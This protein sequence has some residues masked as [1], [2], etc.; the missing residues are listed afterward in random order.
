MAPID[1]LC[2]GSNTFPTLSWTDV[3]GE[4]AEIAIALSDQTDPENPTLIWLMVGIDPALGELPGG[5]LPA[6]AAETLNDYAQLGYGNPCLEQLGKR[7]PRPPVS[8][9]RPTNS[10]RNC[11]GSP[12]A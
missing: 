4:A 5:Q 9:L 6:G 2:A 10:L 11:A 3:P 8:D 1:A 12:W 7:A